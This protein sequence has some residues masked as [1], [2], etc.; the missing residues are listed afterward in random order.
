MYYVTHKIK[1]KIL[2]WF[3]M[4]L[5]RPSKCV[6]YVKDLERYRERRKRR[7]RDTFRRGWAAWRAERRAIWSDR[8][9]ADKNQR[10]MDCPHW[11]SFAIDCD[12]ETKSTTISF[13]F[14]ISISIP[15]Q[16]IQKKMWPPVDHFDTNT[17]AHNHT[18]T[19]AR[20]KTYLKKKAQ[21]KKNTG[22]RSWVG[23]CYLV[24]RCNAIKCKTIR[25]KQNQMANGGVVGAGAGAG[26]KRGATS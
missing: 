16:L 14:E 9:S 5:T 15:I 17:H 12:R 13:F 20:K 19:H 1:D 25:N 11:L 22:A 4:K 18:H 10:P 26:A 24:E 6:F 8:V 2:I 3:E 21:T 7:L 23:R